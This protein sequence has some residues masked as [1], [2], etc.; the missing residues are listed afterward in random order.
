MG[1]EV[2]EGLLKV[3]GHFRAVLEIFRALHNS[4]GV[5]S[6]VFRLVSEQFQGTDR[7]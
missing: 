7:T 3:S 4:F 5:V 6:G 2:L 1:F